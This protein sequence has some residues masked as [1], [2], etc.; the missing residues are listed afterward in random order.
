MK[1]PFF[2]HWKVRTVSEYCSACVSR[3][4]LSTKQATEPYSDNL[5]K[6]TQ[7]PSEP[8]SDKEVLL[9]SFEAG[10]FVSWILNWESTENWDFQRLEPYTKP[11]SDQGRANHEVQTVNW[12][13]GILEVKS[14]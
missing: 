5:V 8:Y 14:A 13:N 7:N 2:F 9:K 3:V 11:Y 10:C 4:G 12:N 1:R 6:R